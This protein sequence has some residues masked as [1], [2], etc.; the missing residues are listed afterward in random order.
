MSDKTTSSMDIQVK[1]TGDASGLKPLEGSLNDLN[2]ALAAAKKEFAAATP[3]TA[4]YDAAV[5]RVG[6]LSLRIKEVLT[7]LREFA[8][9]EV[10]AAEAAAKMNA[11]A[12]ASKLALEAE[13]AAA[14]AAATEL[15]KLAQ[16][17]AANDREMRAN[18]VLSAQRQT[19]ADLREAELRTTRLYEASKKVNE[20]HKKTKGVLDPAA[21]ST[22][23]Y[24]ASILSF[25]QGLEDLQ[26]GIR[27]VLNN[28]P[29]LVMQMGGTMG[30]AGVI[31]VV[32]VGLTVL[33]G[34]LGDLEEKAEAVN[35]AKLTPDEA[36]VKRLEKVNLLLEEQA[37]K[38]DKLTQ[39]WTRKAEAQKKALDLERE[40]NDH[41][42][43]M[44]KLNGMDDAQGS[45]DGLGD[46]T[47]TRQNTVEAAEF[48]AAGKKVAADR[49]AEAAAQAEARARQQEQRVKDLER[50]A[51]LEAEETE[52][53]KKLQ[54]AQAALARAEGGSR[55]MLPASGRASFQKTIDA[56]QANL[57]RVRGN[58]TTLPNLNVERS[59]DA[60]KD[61]KALND[62]LQRE[63][64]LATQRRGDAR[65]SRTSAEGAGNEAAVAAQALEALKRRT[66]WEQERDERE[67]EMKVAQQSGQ[68][69]PLPKLPGEPRQTPDGG[70]FQVPKEVDPEV[71]AGIEA[72]TKERNQADAV[73][74]M[75]R[76]LEDSIQAAK[77]GPV[78]AMLEALLEALTDGQ[79]DTAA[80]L[81]QIQAMYTQIGNDKSQAVSA[82]KSTVEAVAE[83]SRNNAAAVSGLLEIVRTQGQQMRE[84]KQQVDAQRANSRQ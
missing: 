40:Y 44:R 46:R 1:A 15:Q 17:K 83:M 6:Q 4:A 11:Q 70:P 36:E 7:P 54:D 62:A 28:I 64:E 49:E 55:G 10:E 76:K 45:I 59:G 56:A 79:G 66:R 74:A 12:A 37:Q 53:A 48:D 13:A 78:A 63:R 43:E 26:Y 69:E 35:W 19:A 22:R 27:G 31:S 57:S 3:G 72:E 21:E 20:E 58:L 9:K 75:K 65:T 51:E 14:K 32:A 23:N 38:L 29:N 52:A 50:R 71:E 82:L 84:L 77:G 39:A 41:Q 68:P 25:S 16:A 33:V 5:E 2:I 42:E 60:D 34:H 18:A 61:A 67:T 24:G 30:L 47:R 73:E 8:D 80:E 81:A